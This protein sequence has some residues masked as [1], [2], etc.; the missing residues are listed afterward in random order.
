MSDD[1]ARPAPP[2]TDDRQT[3]A[4]RSGSVI[5]VTESSDGWWSWLFRG[6]GVELHSPERYADHADAHRAASLAYPGVPTR[7]EQRTYGPGRSRGAVETRSDAWRLVLIAVV[8]AGVLIA[9]AMT[10]AARAIRGVA[11]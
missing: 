3:D 8:V 2:S 5:V 4:S 6:E 10:R 1:P 11:A 7:V 9:R